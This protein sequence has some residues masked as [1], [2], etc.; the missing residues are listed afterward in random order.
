MRVISWNIR[1]NNRRAKKAVQFALTQKP[2]VLCLQEVSQHILKHLR[3]IPGYSVHAS[4]DFISKNPKRNGYTVTV[5]QYP[6]TYEIGIP[7]DDQSSK[8]ILDLFLYKK[9]FRSIE[10]HNAILITVQ[11]AL[12]PLYIVN[13]R[14]S[15]V[16]NTRDRLI[17]FQNLISNV[18]TNIPTIFCGDYNV[19]DSQLINRLTGWLRGFKRPDYLLNERKEFE[20]LFTKHNLVNIFRGRSTSVFNVPLLQ[21]DHILI[22]NSLNVQKKAIFKKRF[23]SD[24]RML[25]AEII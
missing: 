23:G 25:F 2:D 3:D 24:H 15:C 9:L 21:L 20:M 7:Y 22:P 5:T 17:K 11:T 1:K 12:G 16:V 8:S 14:L 6:V 19:V 18:P 13:T 10:Q 4:Y